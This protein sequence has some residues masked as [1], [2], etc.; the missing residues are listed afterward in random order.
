MVEYA[1]QTLENK[2]KKF[3]AKLDSGLS[4]AD[5]LKTALHWVKFCINYY[6]FVE[7]SHLD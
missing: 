1:I 3:L 5:D 7:L 6:L 2:N 4:I